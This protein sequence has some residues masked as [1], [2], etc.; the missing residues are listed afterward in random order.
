MLFQ[1]ND[2]SKA[3]IDKLLAFAKQNQLQLSLVDDTEEN[4]FLPGKPLSPAQ[5]SVMIE[6][7][8]KSGMVSM[9]NAHEIIRMTYNAG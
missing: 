2:T 3:N 4:L 8:R 5:L 7:S 1:S 9:E 6:K